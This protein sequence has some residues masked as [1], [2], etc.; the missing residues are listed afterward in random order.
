MYILVIV[1]QT[2]VNILSNIQ[3]KQLYIDRYPP[4]RP[5]YIYIPTVPSFDYLIQIPSD[6]EFNQIYNNLKTI[7]LSKI[8]FMVSE[9]LIL[10]NQTITL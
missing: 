1:N 7:Y 5:L 3:T 8:H 9:H 4:P 6:L 2:Y 10:D